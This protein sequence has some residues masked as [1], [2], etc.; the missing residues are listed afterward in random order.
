MSCEGACSYGDVRLTENSEWLPFALEV[1]LQAHRLLKNF[2]DFYSYHA[3]KCC[4][5]NYDAVPLHAA[6]DIVTVA[7]TTAICENMPKRGSQ[8]PGLFRNVL[9]CVRCRDNQILPEN[10]VRKVDAVLTC[11]QKRCAVENVMCQLK[12]I[13][14]TLQRISSCA[15]SKKLQTLSLL[16]KEIMKK[17]ICPDYHL[18]EPPLNDANNELMLNLVNNFI[19]DWSEKR[20]WARPGFRICRFCDRVVNETTRQWGTFCCKDAQQ[21]YNIHKEWA[22][23]QSIS[24][25]GKEEPDDSEKTSKFRKQDLFADYKKSDGKF[26]EE[27]ESAKGKRKDFDR[28]IKHPSVREISATRRTVAEVSSRKTE[29]E[30]YDDSSRERNKFIGVEGRDL[31]KTATRTFEG[32]MRGEIKRSRNI[33]RSGGYPI[34]PDGRPRRDNVPYKSELDGA[35]RSRSL[36]DTKLEKGAA[37]GKMKKIKRSGEYSNRSERVGLSDME[38]EGDTVKRSKRGTKNAS[39][40]EG[41]TQRIRDRDMLMENEKEKRMKKKN[42]IDIEGKTMDQR[43]GKASRKAKSPDKMDEMV[44]ASEGNEIRGKRRKKRDA[45]DSERKEVS[46]SVYEEDKVLRRDEKRKSRSSGEADETDPDLTKKR[47]GMKIGTSTEDKSTLNS[48]VYEKSRLGKKRRDQADSSKMEADDTYTKTSRFSQPKGKMDATKLY[49]TELDDQ[50]SIEYQLSDQYFMELGWTVLPIAK[51]M[52]EI[53]LYETKPAKA[54]I[55]WF[56]K[57][58]SKGKIYYKNGSIFVKFIYDGSA[59]V[60][61]PNGVVALKIE[62]TKTPKYDMYTVFSPGGKDCMGVERK[63]Q[64]VAVFDSVGNG[65]IFDENGATRLS[66]NQIGGIWR[67][68]P[69]GIPLIWKWDTVEK[70]SILKTMQEEKS[71]V[72]LEQLLYPSTNAI[73]VSS[74]SD[75]VSTSVASSK[76]KTKMVANQKSYVSEQEEEEEEEIEPNYAKDI[77]HFRIICLK[78]NDYISVRILNRRNISLQ[79]FA[80]SDTIRIELGTVLNLNKIVESYFVDSSSIEDML[81]CKFEKIR[82]PHFKWENSSMCD[83]AKE[84]Q[85][86]RQSARQRKFMMNKYRPFLRMWKMSG[87]RCRPL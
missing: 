54:H 48:E 39:L 62:R 21:F 50:S 33:D 42:T 73:L 72:R 58:E 27:H 51:T 45:L 74:A 20:S 85:K 87:T 82:S 8:R 70:K 47:K 11:V 60:F 23:Q 13:L 59:E 16:L 2:M 32:K 52:R 63:S 5:I 25:I 44:D 6:L 65:A 1:F 68:N 24:S 41:K 71:V 56:E 7:M 9:P 79:L 66:Y 61:Y 78:L 18:E 49:R 55:D 84:F 46:Y 69:T 43:S 57:N 28:T 86:V 36:R 17:F 29:V 64:I 15:P 77:Y 26:G 30:K 75:K 3:G 31:T 67:D 14:C 19:H 34:T 10:I 81:K 53:V 40:A 80:N 22:L 35:R 37:T 12:D 4:G 76:N 38:L 83:I